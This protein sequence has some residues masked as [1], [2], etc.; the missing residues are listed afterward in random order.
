MA[1]PVDYDTVP[2][3]GRYVYLDGTPATGQIRFTGKVIVTSGAT[4]TIIVPTSITATLDASGGFTVNLPATDDPDVLPNGWTYTVEEK[5]T[6]GGTRTFDIDVPLSAKAAGIDL[7]EVAPLSPSHGDPTAFPTLTMF[8]ELDDRVTATEAV[9]ATAAKTVDI[10]SFTAPGTFTWNKPVGAKMIE[11][12]VVA[13]GGGGGS[14]RRGAA[15][16]VRCGGGGGG[17][18]SWT[19]ALLNADD[20]PASCPLTVGAGGLGGS[21]FA[22]N[23]NSNG[24]SGGTGGSS[25]FNDSVAGSST[26]RRVKAGGGSA[27]QGGTNANGTGGNGGFGLWTGGVG[28]NAQ[29]AGLAGNTGGD[30][31]GPAGGGSGGGITV[32]DVAAS[33]G[34]G[35]VNSTLD[36]LRAAGGIAPGGVGEDGR[37]TLSMGPGNGAGGGAG[38]I[39]GPG[40]V[41]GIGGAYGGGGGGG[42]P[43]LNGNSV[44]AGGRGGHGAIFVITYF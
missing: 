11:V 32:A 29:V 4:D 18:G 17:G 35:G 42:G 38:S 22:V 31:P 36:Q 30:P 3:R 25:V 34:V 15:A 1:L 8:I 24:S 14:G 43:S 37:A 33:G 44:G 40:G 21:S 13:G 27:G 26:A 6:P 7:S 16:T 10:Q 2:V 39:T 41:G 9:T 28:G 23:D 19:R 5:L 20:V 12:L